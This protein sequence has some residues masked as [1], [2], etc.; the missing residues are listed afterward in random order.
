M[1]KITALLITLYTAIQTLPERAQRRRAEADRLATQRGS[2]TL[3]QILWYAGISA[4]CL[5]V[6][7]IVVAIITA[8]AGEIQS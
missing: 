6:I 8:K 4:V 7:G 3:E 1:N 5:I 2:I